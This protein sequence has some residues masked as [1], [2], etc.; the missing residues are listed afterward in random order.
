MGLLPAMVFKCFRDYARGKFPGELRDELDFGVDCVG[1]ADVA[2]EK[3]DDDDRGLA[4]RFVFG[5]GMRGE[6]RACG[7]N[8]G[9]DKREKAK[10]GTH[11]AHLRQ[12]D[13]SKKW[14]RWNTTF[15]TARGVRRY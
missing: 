7:H 14:E 5:C 9:K 3:A 8:G 11:P 2:A 10:R 4:A 6:C 1:V 12:G 15:V 13:S